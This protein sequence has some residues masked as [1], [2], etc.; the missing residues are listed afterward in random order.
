[1]LLEFRMHEVELK[2]TD[3]F[4]CTVPYDDFGVVSIFI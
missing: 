2:K 3:N 1:M 4:G